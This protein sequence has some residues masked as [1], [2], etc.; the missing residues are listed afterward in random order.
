MDFD[1]YFDAHGSNLYPLRGAC[2]FGSS[3]FRLILQDLIFT[4]FILDFYLSTAY[5]SCSEIRSGIMVNHR[6]GSTAP[7]VRSFAVSPKGCSPAGIGQSLAEIAENAEIRPRLA[8]NDRRKCRTCP[9]LSPGE[10]RQ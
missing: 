7:T 3:S 8:E 6:D 10:C 1:L 9:N 4:K 2:L 5:I